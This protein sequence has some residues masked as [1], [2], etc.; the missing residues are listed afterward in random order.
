MYSLGKFLRRHRSQTVTSLVIAVLI[1]GMLVVLSIWNQ[2]RLQLAK[3]ESLTHESILYKARESY[4]KGDRKKAL[5]YV[6]SIL[7][8]RHVGPDAQLLSA[9]IQVDE[10]LYDDAVAELE[11]L[12]DERP[13]IAGAAY[14]LLA[15]ALWESQP[16]DV[17]KVREIEEYQQRAEE[18]LP[19]TAEAYFLRAMTAPTIK[20]KLELLDEALDID[21]G[22]YESRRMR[23]FIS[24]ASQKYNKMEH[25]AYAMVLLQLQNPL[26]YSLHAMALRELGHFEDA[27]AEYNKAIELTPRTDP[28]YTDLHSQRCEILLRMSDYEQVIEAGRECLEH[29]PDKIV[30]H[31]YV[32]SAFTA[33]GAYEEA[34]L[35][36][37]QMINADPHSRNRFRD[38][39]AKLVFDTLGAGQLWHP[40]D[41]EPEGAAF[42][43][44][45]EADKTYRQLSTKTRRLISNGFEP[46]WSPN[47]SKLAFGLGVIGNSGIAVFD[48][49]SQEIDLLIVPGMTPRWSPDGQN[50]AFVRGR[51][52]LSLAEL[53]AIESKNQ[54]G[55]TPAEVW[56]MKKDGTDPRRLARGGWPSWSPDSKHIYFKANSNMLYSIPVEDKEA[57]T[58]PIM[59]FSVYTASVS[60]DNRHVAYVTDHQFLK[61]KDLNSQTLVTD[62][63]GPPR[64]FAGHWSADNQELS[65][66]GYYLGG[67]ARDQTGLWI[68]DLD[69][70]QAAKVLDGQ[71]TTASWAP[72]GRKLA[73]ALEQPLTEIWVADL[74]PNVST[75]ESLGSAQTLEQYYKEMVS[76]YTRM[77]EADPED[78]GGYLLRAQYHNFLGG[79]ESY[80]ADMDIYVTICNPTGY[81]IGKPK[82]L[83]RI[84][85]SSLWDGQPYISADG[86]ELY[87]NSNR[88]GG[89]GGYDIWITTRETIQD[90]WGEPMNLGPPIN[91]AADECGLSITANGLELYFSSNRLGGSGGV[92]IWVMTRTSISKPWGEP[93][94]LGPTV[95]SSV[96]EVGIS[97]SKDGLSLIFDSDRSGGYGGMDLWVSTRPTL[98]DSWSAPENPGPMVNS[99]EWDFAPALSADGLLLFF[100]SSRSGGYG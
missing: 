35:Q 65:I 79:Q 77:I 5:G 28:S 20:E 66:G 90:P 4:A 47:G 87:F 54:I 17:E 32:F 52:F 38:L 49:A 93:M 57:E 100:G 43:F 16:L 14:A 15:R 97:I 13:E 2:N 84:V 88:P 33:L 55:S 75:A 56:I 96:D 63:M 44:M 70:K 45:L 12:L 41:S 26:G 46:S 11:N 6:E 71:I 31:F 40:P 9:S 19:E 73:F 22:H 72:D 53:T 29:L 58:K 37:H 30:F 18:L 21:R 34:T 60:P 91:S 83:G 24:Y 25:D 61:I 85:N 23:A 1:A 3:A 64:I 74:D 69:R 78:T 80:R 81:S 95:N 62:W 67:W 51:Q 36:Y 99:S 59:A 42:F 89:W 98:S 27:F 86:L 7:N 94:N 92:D 82:N 48:L 68:Y 76:H 50:I 39:C 10:R 8:S